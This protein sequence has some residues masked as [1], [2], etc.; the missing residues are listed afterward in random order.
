[1]S[2]YEN[3]QTSAS[4]LND[5][6][7]PEIKKRFSKYYNMLHY[8]ILGTSI[9]M[10]LVGFVYSFYLSLRTVG[11]KLPHD[12]KDE[13]KFF[14]SLFYISFP[15]LT[16]WFCVFFIRYQRKMYKAITD[17]P[18]EAFTDE[19]CIKDIGDYLETMQNISKMLV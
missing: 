4:N 12:I 13:W 9:S 11:N 16:T 17:L 5:E 6:D 15:V 18:D 2:L 19:D 7:Q 8:T 10:F 3:G 14:G 1:M